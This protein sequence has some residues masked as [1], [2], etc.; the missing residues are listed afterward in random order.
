LFGEPYVITGNKYLGPYVIDAT[1]LFG[2]WDILEGERLNR[3]EEQATI[4]YDAVVQSPVT[5]EQILE[6]GRHQLTSIFVQSPVRNV[7]FGEGILVGGGE[8]EIGQRVEHL[9]RK[10]GRRRPHPGRLAALAGWLVP[11]AAAALTV[12]AVI[13]AAGWMA[14]AGAALIT[15]VA[16][17]V[18]VLTMV[19]L[20]TSTKNANAHRQ[21]IIHPERLRDIVSRR[22]TIWVGIGAA[23][24]GAAAA[25]GAVVLTQALA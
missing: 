1:T 24:L 4:F 6:K 7:H 13:T 20:A 8:D 18:A 23:V 10:M 14:I 3:A 25:L 12:V 9:L 19:V 16:V 11:L 21:V 22:V 15:L 5:R 17:A 2:V